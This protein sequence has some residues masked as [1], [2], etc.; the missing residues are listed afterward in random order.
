[1]SS[2]D[3]SLVKEASALLDKFSA[4]EQSLD[5]FI[6]DAEKDLQVSKVKSFF[7]KNRQNI[8]VV[9]KQE[10]SLPVIQSF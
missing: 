9:V 7:Q 1:M 10:K 8:L 3:G 2:D 6:E 4:N 5:G